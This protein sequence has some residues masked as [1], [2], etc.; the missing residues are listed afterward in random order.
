MNEQVSLVPYLLSLLYE[1][2]GLD[3]ISLNQYILN[4]C[5]V[6]GRGCISHGQYP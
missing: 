3:L 4:L 6:L 2:V 1:M 5:H